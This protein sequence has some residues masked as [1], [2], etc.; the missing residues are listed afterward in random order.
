[1]KNNQSAIKIAHNPENRK[2]TRHINIRHHFIR[3]FVME[4]TTL[5]GIELATVGWERCW[6]AVTWIPSNN[7]L[8]IEMLRE[9]FID[10]AYLCA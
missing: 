1:M 9:W 7:S 6:G 10:Q 5:K 4:G 2:K 8:I 3:K